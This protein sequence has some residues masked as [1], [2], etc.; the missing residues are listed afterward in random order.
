MFEVNFIEI[1]KQKTTFA[2]EPTQ[3]RSTVP[4]QRVAHEQLYIVQC[5]VLYKEY[6]A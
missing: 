5:K 4:I 1:V 2:K 6:S 3:Q